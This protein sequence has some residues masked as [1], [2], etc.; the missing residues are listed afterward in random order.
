MKK[1]VLYIIYIIRNH[2][3]QH[4]ATPIRLMQ[5]LYLIDWKH[6]L[7]YNFQLTELKWQI[8]HNY[9]ICLDYQ[10]LFINY[11][12]N[13][14]IKVSLD[15]KEKKIIDFVLTKSDKLS[16]EKLNKLIESTYPFIK[17]GKPDSILNLNKLVG[18]LNNNMILS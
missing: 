18:E 2:T 8:I 17:N 3:E 13:K 1:E 11:N 9:P 15:P 12:N 14:K 7:V 16:S 6:A 5:I 4:E 10:S